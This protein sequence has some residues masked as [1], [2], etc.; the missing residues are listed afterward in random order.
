M[1]DNSTLR[2]RL[3][4]YLDSYPSYEVVSGQNP[5]GTGT[6]GVLSEVLINHS[7]GQIFLYFGPAEN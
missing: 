6:V 2:N 5:D 7:T 3:L 4:G 1:F